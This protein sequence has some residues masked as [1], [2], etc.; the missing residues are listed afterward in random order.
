MSVCI[1]YHHFHDYHPSVI[2]AASVCA[3]RYCLNLIPVFPNQLQDISPYRYVCVFHLC[4]RARC[5]VLTEAIVF[6][7][8]W[9]CQL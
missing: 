9:N 8:R 1:Q 6:I 5:L 4:I 2:A 7:Q 3:T